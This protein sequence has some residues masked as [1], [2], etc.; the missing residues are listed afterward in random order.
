MQT[1]IIAAIASGAAAVIVSQFWQ[2]GTIIASAMTPVM[3]AL[4]SEA[5]R[6]PMQSERVIRSVSAVTSTARPRSGR[7][8]SVIAPPTPGVEEGKAQRDGGIEPGP[9]KVYGGT[10]GKGGWRTALARLDRRHLRIALVTGG[11]GFLIAAAALTLPELIFGGSVS[12][13]NRST[14][15]FGG[16]SSKSDA[17]DKSDPNSSGDSTDGQTQPDSTTPRDSTTTTPDSSTPSTTPQDTTP[18]DTTTTTPPPTTTTPP[19]TEAPAPVQPV[20]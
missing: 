16:G 6:K 3:V 5:L 7:T 1:L 19:P 4:V 8:P 14:T 20:P 13:G 9:V 17:T 11:I 2:R 18:S 15:I 12:G 10:N